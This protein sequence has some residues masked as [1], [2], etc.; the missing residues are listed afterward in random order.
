MKGSG[1]RKLTLS[2]VWAVLVAAGFGLGL[3]PA[4][5]LPVCNNCGC[6][7]VSAWL[8]VGDVPRS[9][10]ASWNMQPNYVAMDLYTNQN[11]LTGHPLQCCT[12][13]VEILTWTNSAPVCT[14][15]TFT[16][17]VTPAGTATLDEPNANDFIC[18]A[19]GG[20]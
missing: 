16:Q 14:G 7:L 5:A 6:V 4:R 10:Q 11:C 2:V 18:D 9:I 1:M 20:E 15:A 19:E 13:C 8:Q 17:E 3:Q 12:G